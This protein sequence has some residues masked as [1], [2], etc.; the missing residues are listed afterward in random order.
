M[1]KFCLGCLRLSRW[2][3]TLGVRVW[4][5]V[6]SSERVGM[7]K[8]RRESRAATVVSDG[9]VHGETLGFWLCQVCAW[10]YDNDREYNRKMAVYAALKR[11]TPPEGFT[12][13]TV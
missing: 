7:A 4:D 10:L 8:N 1:A 2:D 9:T 3:S 13:W 5:G 6:V 12:G 11:H